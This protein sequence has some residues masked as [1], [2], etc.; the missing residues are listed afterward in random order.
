MLGIPPRETWPTI[1]GF[2]LKCLSFRA[3][4]HK[5]LFHPG[6]HLRKERIVLYQLAMVISLAAEC[7]ATYSLSKYEDLQKHLEIRFIGQGHG[8]HLYNN[9]IIDPQISAIV[10]CVMVACV[11]GA[12]FFFLAMWPERTYPR[13]YNH[14]KLA[15]A[16]FISLGMF[17]S[18]VA[19]TVVVATQSA[20]LNLTGATRAAA[21]AE[22]FRPPLQYNQWATNIAFVV[23][24]W[25]ATVFVVIANVVMLLAVRHDNQFGTLPYCGEREERARAG[26]YG[27]KNA[28]DVRGRGPSIAGS[29]VGSVGTGSVGATSAPEMEEGYASRAFVRG[30]GGGGEQLQRDSGESWGSGGGT[31]TGTPI[32]QR[33]MEERERSGSVA[34]YV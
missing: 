1:W 6:Y 27:L 5:R 32:A 29:V 10:F 12:D 28:L 19:S 33:M 16:L 25:I 2:D 7:T 11:Y 8:V 3:F 4:S 18:T 14:S 24:L 17:A 30:G 26:S 15:F 23:L 34:R 31:G 20:T 22:Y 21:L 9:N 13:W